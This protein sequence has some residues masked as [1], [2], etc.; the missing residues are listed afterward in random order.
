MGKTTIPLL[1]WMLFTLAVVTTTTS[2]LQAIE[3]DEQGCIDSDVIFESGHGCWVH[4]DTGENADRPVRVWY[5]YPENFSSGSRKVV[6]AMHGSKRNAN[7]AIARWQPYADEYGALIIAPEFSLDDYPKARHYNRGNVRDASGEIQSPADWTFTTIEEI[8]DQVISLIPD[9]PQLYSI[10]GHSA[11]GQFVHRMALLG[12]NYRIETA[13][14][15]NPGWYLLPDENYLYPC[16]I[17]NLPP[18]AVDLATA[19]AGNLVITLGTKDNDPNATGLNHGSCAEM[20]GAN[21]YDRG[22][23]FHEYA[24]KDA[25]NRGL[26]FKWKLVGVEGIGHDAD[27][28][29]EAGADEILG[30]L[31]HK[32][33]LLLYPTQDATVKANY[34][35]SNYG[36]RDIL[37]VDGQSLKTTYLQFD[38][39]SVTK[40]DAAILRVDVTDPSSGLQSIHEAKSNLWSETG[41]TYNNQPGIADLITTLNGSGTGELSIDLSNFIHSRLG[42]IITLVLSSTNADG[43]YFSSRESS[44]PPILELY[45]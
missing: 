30:T 12:I 29:V 33:P 14:A 25:L 36:L 28:M 1:S 27:A 4:H 13:V 26:P 40:I 38:L 19:Y 2:P 3:Y 16:G 15:A 37:Q 7:N 24:R 34:P 6:F 42:Q 11:G 22:H 10:Q 32:D 9:A 5:Y 23:F 41:L 18:Q 44:S 35:N 17:A 21:R 20:Q 31:Y 8:F 39:R 43:L 45:Q